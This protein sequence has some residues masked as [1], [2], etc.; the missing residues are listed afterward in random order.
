MFAVY[1]LLFR[2][3]NSS[4][5]IVFDLLSYDY[6]AQIERFIKRHYVRH[7]DTNMILKVK[8]RISPE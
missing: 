4:A 3:S 2:F 6:R 1:N 8:F 7:C 5:K